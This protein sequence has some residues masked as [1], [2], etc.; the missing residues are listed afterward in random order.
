[1]ARDHDLSRGVDVGGRNHFSVG[2]LAANL[3]HALQADPEQR[4][5]SAGPDRHGFLHVLPA[6]ADAPQRVG[7]GKRTGGDQSGVLAE[8]VARY[9]RRSD[10]ALRHHAISGDGTGQHR[11]LGVGGELK[12]FGGAFKTEPGK[13]EAE[14]VVGLRESL[15]GH[16]KVLPQLAR[17]AR[18]LRAL[19]GK[20][21][22]EFG[23]CV[24]WAT[25]IA[26]LAAKTPERAS[27]P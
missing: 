9:Q 27:P 6:T 14:R 18:L 10:T 13:R 20:K 4:G 3:F 26:G 16:R 21:K 2:G 15:A 5:H 7:E 24:R 23:H 11:R 17:H 8:A 25:W 22:C 12:L 19:S 1:M